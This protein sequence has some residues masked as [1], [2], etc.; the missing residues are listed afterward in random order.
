[1]CA[2]SLS[3]S[4]FFQSWHVTFALIVKIVTRTSKLAV[5]I[6]SRHITWLREFHVTTER[7]AGHPIRRRVYLISHDDE[8]LRRVHCSVSR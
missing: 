5:D 3:L 6:L 7:T 8:R 1:M 4:L 2:A